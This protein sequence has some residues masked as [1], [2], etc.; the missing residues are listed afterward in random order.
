MLTTSASGEQFRRVEQLHIHLTGKGFR[1]KG[2]VGYDAYAESLCSPSHGPSD[3]PEPEDAEGLPLKA[4]DVR[5]GVPLP[6]SVGLYAPVVVHEAA[7]EREEQG[8][9]MI[10]NFLRAIWAIGHDRNTLFPCGRG[11]DPVPAHGGYGDGLA[12]VQRVEDFGVDGHV[13]YQ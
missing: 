11:V 9:R 6:E 3:G 2:I 10:C 4:A 8:Q 13:G 7:V 5:K 1:H 12:D